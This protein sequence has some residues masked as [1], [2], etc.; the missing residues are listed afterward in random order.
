MSATTVV[1][2][3]ETGRNRD[4]GAG[5]TIAIADYYRNIDPG[6][7]RQVGAWR[8]A[9]GVEFVD[10]LR[11]SH[12]CWE[13]AKVEAPGYFH[14]FVQAES[15]NIGGELN[16]V[17]LHRGV[18]P[19]GTVRVTQPEDVIRAFGI[20]PARSLQVSMTRKA[21]WD[22]AVELAMQPG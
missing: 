9:E 15:H 14:F 3:S 4:P 22:C 17:L 20:G 5:P 11:H 12:G 19:A 10:R 6:I 21:L 2:P 18:R 8:Q 7:E 13:A 1:P 16:G